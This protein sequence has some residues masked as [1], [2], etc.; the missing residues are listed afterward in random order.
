MTRSY[1]L[2]TQLNAWA[3]YLPVGSAVAPLRRVPR[4]Q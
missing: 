2:V 1:R 4:R 3:G